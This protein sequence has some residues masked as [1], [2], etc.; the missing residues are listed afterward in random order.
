MRSAVSP[1]MVSTLLEVAG[2][3]PE[4]ARPDAAAA[5]VT[6]QLEGTRQAFAE[7]AFEDEPSAFA[8][9]LRGRAQ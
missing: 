7:L 9:E 2:V 3:A 1:Q 8:L 6:A 5:W 4:A